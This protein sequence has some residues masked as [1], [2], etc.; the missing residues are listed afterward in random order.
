MFLMIQGNVLGAG[1]SAAFG[2]RLLL[3]KFPGAAVAYALLPLSKNFIDQP[4]IRVRRSSDNTERDFTYEEIQNNT[5]LEWSQS[6][7]FD[8]MLLLDE[9]PNAT[10]AYSLR[11]LSVNYNGPVIRARRTIDDTEATFIAKEITDGTLEDWTTGK[12]YKD[13][14][15]V[16]NTENSGVSNNDQFQF[17]GAVGNYDVQVWNEAG[18]AL[19]ETFTGLSGAATITMTGGAGTYELRVFASEVS[20]FNRILF[21]NTGDKDKLIEVRN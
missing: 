6:S 13:F 3:D 14:R 11:N 7:D 8:N 10:S 19:Q 2:N 18:T 1:R 21:N 12:G 16:V 5:L 20:G 15:I 17:T 4:L 9:F